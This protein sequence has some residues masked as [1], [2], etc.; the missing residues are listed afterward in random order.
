VNNQGLLE[1]VASEEDFSGEFGTVRR[2]VSDSRGVRL[3]DFV[4]GLTPVYARIYR[5][6]ALGFGGLVVSV[7]LAMMA[8][9]RGIG[10]VPVG[11]AGGLIIGFWFFYLVSFV[12]EGLHG[13]LTPN[14]RT[15]DRLTG[16]MIA[17]MLGLSLEARRRQ[18]FEH[19]RSLGTTR[20]T[21]MMYFYPLNLSALLK[22]ATGFGALR[23]LFAYVRRAAR[24]S[25]AIKQTV[26]ASA[27][28]GIYKAVLV[29]VI[30]H[31]AIVAVLLWL[32]APGA[33]LAWV[34]AVFSVMPI[35]NTNRQLLEHRHPAARLDVDY[36]TI[37]QGAC[38][39]MFSDGWLDRAFG[40][41]GG[42]QH[43]LHHWE[44][45]VSYTRLADL[46]R[47]LLDTPLRPVIDRRRTTYA[48]ALASLFMLT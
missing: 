44:G 16:A 4:R 10:L 27:D 33:A 8:E 40:P 41:A 23:A 2:A 12:H 22:S 3:V 15:N 42:H 35:L 39:R 1:L 19:H 5:D 48:Q 38:T 47:F 31:G 46:E 21:E 14:R 11:V 37:D 20:D 18:H 13:N 30:T 6:L 7:A 26:P 36:S 24:R 17:C 9:Q 43:L 29:G 45:Q 28:S 34:F 25:A 32:G